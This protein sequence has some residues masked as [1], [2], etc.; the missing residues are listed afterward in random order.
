MTSYGQPKMKQ[1]IDHSALSDL[2]MAIYIIEY[3][4]R[5]SK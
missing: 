5:T 2:R 3:R 1:L 4:M